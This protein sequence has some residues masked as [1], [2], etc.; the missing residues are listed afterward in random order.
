MTE[1]AASSYILIAE[2]NP[3]DVF[4]VREALQDRNLAYD[5]TVLNDGEQAL[6]FV[7]ELD[8]NPGRRCPELLLLDL[9]LPKRDGDAVLRRWRASNRCGQIPVVLFSSSDD[10]LDRQLEN[11]HLRNYYFRKPAS[12]DEFLRLGDFVKEIIEETKRTPTVEK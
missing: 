4:L 10:P 6:Q 3:A 2:D 11:R 9:H 8:R 7:D 5:L 12:L 1:A